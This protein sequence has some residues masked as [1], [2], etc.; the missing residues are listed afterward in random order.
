MTSGSLERYN[1][2]LT[3][4]GLVILEMVAESKEDAAAQLAAKLFEQGRISDLEGFLRDVN[5]RDRETK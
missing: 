3:N 2:E 1:T 4:P 5:A